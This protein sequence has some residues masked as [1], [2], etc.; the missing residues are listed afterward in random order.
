ML[1]DAGKKV[2]AV[3]GIL[4]DASFLDSK[5]VAKSPAINLSDTSFLEE[6]SGDD[7]NGLHDASGPPMTTNIERPNAGGKVEKSPPITL[8]FFK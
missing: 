3:E 5:K 1:K 2:G 7:G 4:S 6:E 8:S